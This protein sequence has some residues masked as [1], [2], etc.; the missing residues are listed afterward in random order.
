[1]PPTT[2]GDRTMKARPLAIA[3]F[4]WSLAPAWGQAHPSRVRPVRAREPA[5]LARDRLA[6]GPG[7]FSLL[8]PRE[9]ES[10]RLPS[11]APRPGKEEVSASVDSGGQNALR[12]KR[13]GGR[14]SQPIYPAPSGH[15]DTVTFRCAMGTASGWPRRTFSLSE[16]AKPKAIRR[17]S[18]GSAPSQ[19][20]SAARPPY[21]NAGM[22]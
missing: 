13:T 4:K 22:A 3:L 16:I 1:M 11:S 7:R 10:A 20:S 12:G 8:R 19:A 18:Q 9:A 5:R 14:S 15:A 17:R 21:A 2:R 6:G